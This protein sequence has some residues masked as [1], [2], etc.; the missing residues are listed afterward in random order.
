MVTNVPFGDVHRLQGSPVAWYRRTIQEALR[1]AP[2]AVLL[3]PDQPAFRQALG[4]VRIER[5]QRFPVQVLGKRADI[6]H[7][8]K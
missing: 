8:D 2:A 6:W 4:R 7:L 3:A 1:V 5:L